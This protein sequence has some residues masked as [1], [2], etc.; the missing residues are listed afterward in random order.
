MEVYD[1]IILGGGVSGISTAYHLK[2]TAKSKPKFIILES[3]ENFGGK[4]KKFQNILKRQWN[5][6]KQKELGEE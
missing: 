3:A 4:I 5:W 1:V 6:S 2:N